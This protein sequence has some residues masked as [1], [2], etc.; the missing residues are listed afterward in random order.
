MEMSDTEFAYKLREMYGNHDNEWTLNRI[1]FD[2]ILLDDSRHDYS[3]YVQVNSDDYITA[4]DSSAFV[5]DAY[6]WIKIDEGMGDLYKYARVN[7]CPAGLMNDAGTYNYKL[8]NG[9]AVYSP[10][11][12]LPSD[13]DIL[14]TL[15]GVEE[16]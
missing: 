14:M 11:S 6:L 2:R 13:H 12:D 15:V 3:V 16:E 4:V 9:K 1:N 5:E 10:Q 8:V 7:Y